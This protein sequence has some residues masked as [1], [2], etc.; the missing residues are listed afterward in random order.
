VDYAQLEDDKLLRLISRAEAKALDELYGRYSRL[1][2]SIAL[3]VAGERA[4][5]EEITLDIF[6]TV[7]QKAHTYRPDRGNVRIWLS[8][9]ARNRAI[10]RLRRERVR[11]DSQSL[12]WSE[13]TNS[14]SS[15][16][17]DPETAVDLNLRQQQIR[18]ALTQL[19]A[20]QRQVLALAYY[21]GYT[22]QEMAKLYNLPLGTVKTRIRLAMQKLRYLLEDE[23]LV[24]E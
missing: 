7:W 10:D 20:E 5:A 18:A 13:I 15:N 8:S 1:V 21:Q 11:L 3:H 2:F 23:R 4:T 19:P 14:P 17:Q 16:E 6:T 24:D 12:P 22:Q 9:M